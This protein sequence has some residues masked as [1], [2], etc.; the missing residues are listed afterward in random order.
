MDYLSA[1]KMNA[2]SVFAIPNHYKIDVNK[3]L[4]AIKQINQVTK[5]YQNKTVTP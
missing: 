3:A 4:E 5:L 1:C 2:N